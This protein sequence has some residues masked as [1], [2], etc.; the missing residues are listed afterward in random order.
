MN[1]ASDQVR[2]FNVDAYLNRLGLDWKSP[3]LDFLKMIQKK[4]LIEIP[5]EN[6]DIHYGKR[7]VLE[8]NKIFQ[9]IIPS[10]RGGYCFELN[11]LLY[12]LLLGLGYKGYLTS[13]S[14]YEKDGTFS[15]P[16]DHMIIIIAIDDLEYI[17][18]AGLVDGIMT[19]KCI[20][21]NEISLDYNRYYKIEKNIDDEYLLKKSTDQ[22]H[23]ET[24]YKFCK[25]PLKLIQFLAINDRHQDHP[26][27]HFVKNKFISRLDENGGRITLSDRKLKLYA[28]GK[29]REIDILNEDEFLSKLDQYFSIKPGDLV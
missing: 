28:E 25:K 6:L 14:F 10:K 12:N 27:S 4:H 24:F 26:D 18:D 1:S 3:T 5:F 21:E 20:I 9:K 19:P 8:I 29:L 23:F 15:D 11:G 7:I 17:V 16:L 22:V 13:A 2:Y